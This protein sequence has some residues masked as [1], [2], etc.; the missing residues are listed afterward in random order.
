MTRDCGALLPMRYGKDNPLPRVQV[1]RVPALWD[2][3]VP[4]LLPQ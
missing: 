1:V 3:D 4:G 2:G